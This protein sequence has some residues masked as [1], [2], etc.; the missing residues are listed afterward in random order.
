MSNLYN[1]KKGASD[2]GDL[3]NTWSGATFTIGTESSNSINVAI[4]LTD[5][6]GGAVA[7]SY[8]VTAYLSDDSTGAGLVATVPDGDI[9]IGTDGTILYELVTD[10]VFVI[11]SEADGDIDLDIGEAGADT[12]YLV[13][14]D[15]AGRKIVSAAITFAA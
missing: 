8:I 7:Q 6:D 9:A 11:E 2:Y 3:K 4:Q 5:I 10:K 13:L 12:F 1:M 15:P 14:I